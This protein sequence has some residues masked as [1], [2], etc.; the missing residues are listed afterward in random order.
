MMHRA[1]FLI[2]FL[3]L[4]AGGA[5]AQTAFVAGTVRDAAG[6]PIELATITV[7]GE[8]SGTHADPQGKYK[9]EVPAGKRITLV[10]SYVST[11]PVKQYFNLAAGETRVADVVLKGRSTEI[12]EV[13]KRESRAPNEAGSVYLLDPSKSNELVSTTDGITA[14]IKSLVGT[15]NEL[16]SQYTVRGGNYDEN[17]VYVNDFEIGRPFLVRSGQQ[18]GL[19]FVNSDLVSSVAFSLGGFQAKYGDKLSLRAGCDLQ[20]AEEICRYGNGFPAWRQPVAGRRFA[21]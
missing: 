7:S 20:A 9:L 4:I 10:Y 14:Q 18:E 12:G 3:L 15:R 6:R 16:T 13:I 8:P 2:V 1:A 19:S 17:L 5:D 21:Q 11:E